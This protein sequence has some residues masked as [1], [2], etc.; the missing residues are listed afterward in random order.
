MAKHIPDDEDAIFGI[1]EPND[2]DDGEDRE[3]AGPGLFDEDDDLFGDLDEDEDEVSTAV[4]THKT[5]I[6]SQKVSQEDIYRFMR[7]NMDELRSSVAEANKINDQEKAEY[8]RQKKEQRE[9]EAL[10]RETEQGNL[11]P[12]EAQ[13]SNEDVFADPLHVGED[14]FGD[15]S[16]KKFT[17]QVTENR[18]LKLSRIMFRAI[19]SFAIAEKKMLKAGL[20]PLDSVVL[21]RKSDGQEDN[22]FELLKSWTTEH[23]I[24]LDS[25]RTRVQTAFSGVYHPRII[26]ALSNDA[27][28][29][30]VHEED[31]RNDEYIYAFP[32]GRLDIEMDMINKNPKLSKLSEIELDAVINKSIADA[33]MSKSVL[34]AAGA[35]AE[36]DGQEEN[37]VI[38]D[39]VDLFT[40]LST[41]LNE[42]HKE[43]VAKSK[44]KIKKFEPV[45]SLDI[46]DG[47]ITTRM[48]SAF[49]IFDI[50]IE[51]GNGNIFLSNDLNISG[52]YMDTP[53]SISG[54]PPQGVNSFSEML[55]EIESH[56]KKNDATG[57]LEDFLTMNSIS[58]STVMG[59]IGFALNEEGKLERSHPPVNEAL[60]IPNIT[61]RENG[62][63]HIEERYIPELDPEPQINVIEHQPEM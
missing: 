50:N 42:T 56:A 31:R 34:N 11:L 44:D 7:G 5:S 48:S 55:S 49:G 2:D 13:E 60:F 38:L 1:H 12:T 9:L 27:T 10:E 45:K 20:N 62:A 3:N 25:E 51:P 63:I 24:R 14:I 18:L 57:Y 28:Y 41:R 47:R 30:F 23:G 35:G 6:R 8:L 4:A 16:W 52:H 43:N 15:I 58:F 61:E 53:F 36:M 59:H 21:K 46:V 39:A 33:D 40:A 54:L 26:V 17:E 29:M 32:F 37:Q 22:Q 19:P